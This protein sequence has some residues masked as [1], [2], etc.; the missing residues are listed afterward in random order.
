MSTALLSGRNLAKLIQQKANDEARDLEN[1]GLRATLAVVV[2]T[3]DGS[4][5]WY[6]RSINGLQKARAS[7]AGSWTWA[8]TRQETYWPQP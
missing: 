1:D 4:T 5:H 7:I 6:V 3:D 8:T 2:A